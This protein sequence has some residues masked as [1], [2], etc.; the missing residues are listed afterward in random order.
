MMFNVTTI[1]A[2]ADGTLRGNPAGV[3]L[4]DAFPN[5]G[6]ML[7]VAKQMGH[8]ETAFL[9]K[10]GD[11]A[12]DL[13]WFTPTQEVP[14]CG[15]ATLA[16]AHYLRQQPL[17]DSARPVRFHTKSG[18]IE[19]RFNGNAIALDLPNSPG[20][21][22]PASSIASCL[23]VP[24]IACQRTAASIL[25]EVAD[26]AA[27][28]DCRPD[29]DAIAK[30]DS[31]DLIVTTATGVTGYDYAYR[32]F[33]PQVGIDEDQVTGSANC[34]LAPYWAAKLGKSEFKVLQASSNGGALDVKLDDK[35]VEVG[36]QALT[37]RTT[38]VEIE[39]ASPAE[40]ARR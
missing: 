16:A 11:N 19:A 32:C 4:L 21:G 27:L 24:V 23:G 34:I 7:A 26:M 35:H 9:V 2:F 18:T 3:C 8:A 36:G 10:R 38:T 20:H 1:N 33:A 13:R 5:D 29:L 14:L 31:E 28:R 15:H 30:L 6:A 39:R 17:V 25:A 12:F 22:F 37:I 40:A